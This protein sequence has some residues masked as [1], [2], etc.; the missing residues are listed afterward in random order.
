VIP[1]RW[2]VVGKVSLMLLLLLSERRC[3]CRWVELRLELRLLALSRS[4]LST[5]PRTWPFAFGRTGPESASDVS[6][7]S[8][9]LE[10]EIEGNAYESSSGAPFSSSS[11]SSASGSD[12]GVPQIRP[13]SMFCRRLRAATSSAPRHS[14]L[15]PSLKIRK[16]VS[17]RVCG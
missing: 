15:T 5:I 14:V 4:H 10:L 16:L 17:A 1:C 8:G 2:V 3:R 11:S 7:R 9:E 6:G 12:V 13:R